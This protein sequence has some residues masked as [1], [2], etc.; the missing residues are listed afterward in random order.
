MVNQLQ[1]F[2]L[3]LNSSNLQT[4]TGPRPLNYP[5]IGRVAAVVGRSTRPSRMPPLWEKNAGTARSVGLPPSSKGTLFNLQLAGLLFLIHSPAF[6]GPGGKW[7]DICR[8]TS[9]LSKSMP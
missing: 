3:F 5:C 6:G 8:S 4:V 9:L 2:H 7:A 1:C